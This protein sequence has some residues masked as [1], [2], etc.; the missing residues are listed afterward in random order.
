MLLL[1]SNLNQFFDKDRTVWKAEK[2][3]MDNMLKA[4]R[5]ALAHICWSGLFWLNYGKLL[6]KGK[7]EKINQ[8]T[9]PVVHSCKCKSQRG[10]FY[11]LLGHVQDTSADFLFNIS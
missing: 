2:R 4:A 5:K 3:V 11:M 8:N 7:Q 10:Q 6:L 1:R 9:D